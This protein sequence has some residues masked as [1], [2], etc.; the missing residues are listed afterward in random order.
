MAVGDRIKSCRQ[1]MGMSQEKLAD[2]LGV[3][4]QA[5]TKWEANLSAPSTENLFKLAELFGTTVDLLLDSNDEEKQPVAEQILCKWET[6]KEKRMVQKNGRS[7][8]VSWPHY[9]LFWGMSSCIFWGVL[10]G[11]ICRRIVLLAG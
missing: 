8:R 9:P 10:S 7:R 1:K 3:S 5:V 11:V 4:R 2:S 6:E